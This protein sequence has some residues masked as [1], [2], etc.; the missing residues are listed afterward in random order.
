MNRKT[1]NS[2]LCTCYMFAPLTALFTLIS[3]SLSYSYFLTLVYHKKQP[4]RFG[5]FSCIKISLTPFSSA[6]LCW[7]RTLKS[8]AF[9]CSLVKWFCVL[10]GDKVLLCGAFLNHKLEICWWKKQWNEVQ[11]LEIFV[12]SLPNLSDC[13]QTRF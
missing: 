2:F 10:N 6:V 7:L 4:D 9:T 1:Y 11:R 5:W 13:S 3:Y 12:F 8:C